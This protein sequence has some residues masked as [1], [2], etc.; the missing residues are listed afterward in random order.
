MKFTKGTVTVSAAQL[1]AL[2]QFVDHSGFSERFDAI[3]FDIGRRTAMATDGRTLCFYGVPVAPSENQVR[4]PSRQIDQLLALCQLSPSNAVVLGPGVE[5]GFPLAEQGPADLVSRPPS[6]SGLLSP[7]W[8]AGL[9]TS[10]WQWRINTKLLAVLAAVQK[11]NE[12]ECRAADLATN[13]MT[14][15]A[16]CGRIN[17]TLFKAGKWTVAIMPLTP[18]TDDFDEAFRVRNAKLVERRRK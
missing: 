4:V 5:H 17:P 12:E 15:H 10:V 7:A 8:A 6:E 18:D 3:W 16:P 2:R 11:A 9:P 1:K 14:V 13:G